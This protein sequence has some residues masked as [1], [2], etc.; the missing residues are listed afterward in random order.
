MK[1][2]KKKLKIKN[3][4]LFICLILIIIFV[5]VA[6][7]NNT[8]SKNKLK[9]LGYSN[10]EISEINKL[11]E[12]E[13]DVI[14]NY[15]Y[16]K[17][18][19]YIIKSDN[20]NKEKLNLY[21]KYLSKYKEIDYKKIIELINQDGFKED[22]A[23]DYF[24][25]LVKYDSIDGIIKYVNTYSNK[26]KINETSLNFINEK[27]F[28]EDYMERYLEYYKNNSNL[29][30]SEIVTRINSNL[31]YTFYE[32]SKEADLS[33]GMYTLVNK[34]YYLD[35]S[36][37]GEDIVSATAEYTA[38]NGK[39]NRLAYENFVKMA[40]A[41]REEGLTIKITT[42][43]RDY[44]FQ[45]TLYNNYVRQDGVSLADTYS[46]RPGYSEH[47]LG[48]SADLTNGDN[49]EFGEFQYTKEYEWLQNNAYKY[50]FIMRY[51]EDKEYITGYM[52]ESWH[53]RYVGLDIAKYIYESNITYEEYYA[54]FL[55]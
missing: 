35:Q 18:L 2:K 3:I 16:N 11:S 5:I 44:Y 47:Q 30:Y 15:K 48:Y 46:A 10:L 29:S 34:Y 1:K 22:K 17:D 49:V 39:L 38:G 50:G 8:P 25:L 7:L 28:I 32:D 42:G 45:R 9:K 27:Y 14:E 20:Y 26:F 12:E 41:A 53:Y 36:Y 51:P 23:K 4:C 43:Y 21:L 52:Y 55:R 54:Y 31:D 37:Q 33:K 6:L 40:D 13:K 19:I 24:E